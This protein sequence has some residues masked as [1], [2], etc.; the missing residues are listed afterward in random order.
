[1]KGLVTFLLTVMLSACTGTYAA[2]NLPTQTTG[3]MTSATLSST[4]TGADYPLSIYLPASYALGAKTYAVIYATDG[5]AGFPPAGRFLNFAEILQRRNIDAI[6]VGIGG[7]SRRNTDYRLP[8]AR[9]YHAFLI[10]ELVPFIES[11]F[12]AD[13]AQRILSGV[14][15]GGSFVVSSLFMEAAK[16]PVFSCYISTEGSFFQPS[17]V[18]QEKAFVSDV[19][20][21]SIPATLILARGAPN[22]TRQQVSSVPGT[23]DTLAFSNLARNLSSE[24]TNHTEVDV[25]YHRMIDRNYPG[26]TIVETT[27]DTDHIGTDNP[28][29]DDAMKRIFK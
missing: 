7:T 13:P 19:G 26:L 8:G 25:F 29:F 23:K 28:A 18:V 15:F 1:M 11:H 4:K 10:D 22:R 16:S 24:A 6:L 9:A 12:R 2:K 14:S 21:K 17:F 27:F 20:N 5:D 3:K